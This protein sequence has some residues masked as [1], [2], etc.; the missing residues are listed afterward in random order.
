MEL[1]HHKEGRVQRKFG[2]FSDLRNHFQRSG[3]QVQA[4]IPEP[5]VSV[6]MEMLGVLFLDCISRIVLEDGRSFIVWGTPYC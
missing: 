4:R 2:N 5:A 1:S 6:H 3:R